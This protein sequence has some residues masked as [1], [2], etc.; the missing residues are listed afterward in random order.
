MQKWVTKEV[1]SRNLGRVAL[2][3]KNVMMSN[4]TCWEDSEKLRKKQAEN[5]EEEME[6]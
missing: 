6:R 4:L 2:R 3:T 5:V 1:V